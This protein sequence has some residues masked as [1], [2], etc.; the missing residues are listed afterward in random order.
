[1]SINARTVP[2]SLHTGGERV[3]FTDFELLKSRFTLR[4]ST[5]IAFPVRV[6]V[7]CGRRA[8]SRLTSARTQLTEV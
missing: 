6:R 5:S 1:M 3:L 8:G 2:S 7:L 4:A